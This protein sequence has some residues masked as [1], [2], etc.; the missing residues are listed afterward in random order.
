MPKHYKAQLDHRPF[1]WLSAFV[2]IRAELET[3]REQ[4]LEIVGFYDEYERGINE[5]GRAS[6]IREEADGV[7]TDV[8]GAPLRRLQPSLIAALNPPKRLLPQ[9][10]R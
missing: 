8:A 7:L 6:H 5:P 4:V 9:C 2:Q 3:R 10:V 1:D